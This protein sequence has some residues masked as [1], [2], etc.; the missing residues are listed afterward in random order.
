[1]QKTI[2]IF[3]YGYTGKFLAEKLINKGYIIYCTSRKIKIDEI[4]Q[5]DNIKIINFFNNKLYNIIQKADAILSTIPTTNNSFIDPVLELYGKI[6]SKQ[7]FLWAGY[8]SSTGVYGDH[9][10]EWVNEQALC[11][12]SNAKTKARLSVE[13]QWLSLYYSHKIP[14]HIFRLSAIY[15]PNRNCL[16]EIKK[17]KNFTIVKNDQYFSRIHIDD[18]CQVIIHSLNNPTAGEIYN[19]SDNKPAPLH[20]VQQFGAKILK[21]N[22][23]HEIY[24]NETDMSL[25]MKI[26]FQDNKKI[27][28]HKMIQNLNIKLKYPDYQ[29][30]LANGCLPFLTN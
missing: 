10:G 23:L 16:E 17:G 18:I 20:I 30:G 14:M 5:H 21:C 15:G 29:I 7:Q 9:N 8:L 28:N 19:V 11:L 13:Q 25:D 6:I 12:P 4:Y 3:G 26:F 27:S 1:M 2:V 24:W 22:K